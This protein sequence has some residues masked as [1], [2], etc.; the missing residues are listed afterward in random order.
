MDIS[1]C[2][3]TVEVKVNGIQS[4]KVE[5]DPSRP[6]GHLLMQMHAGNESWG[7]C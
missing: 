4:A 3:R 7:W 6:I 5:N 2:G 1:A